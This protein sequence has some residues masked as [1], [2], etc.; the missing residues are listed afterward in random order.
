MGM[1]RDLGNMP[2]EGCGLS[3]EIELIVGWDIDDY[4]IY[5]IANSR[6][7]NLST[8]VENLCIPCEDKRAEAFPS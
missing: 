8:G 3:D 6:S 4:Q 5:V 7:S 1:K 2:I